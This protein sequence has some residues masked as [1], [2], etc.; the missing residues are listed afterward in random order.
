M[1]APS[2]E[3]VKVK[4]ER[5]TAM[6]ARGMS[7]TIPP[8][9][10]RKGHNCI[11]GRGPKAGIASKGGC[12]DSADYFLTQAEGGFLTMLWRSVIKILTNLSY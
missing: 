3:V 6:R 1:A 8:A 5:R 12:V 11:E 9:N 2:I 7:D 10:R 4:V